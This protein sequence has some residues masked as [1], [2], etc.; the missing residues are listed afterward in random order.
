MEIENTVEKARNKDIVK[1]LTDQQLNKLIGSYMCL[2]CMNS[3]TGHCATGRPLGEE[4]IS[5]YQ[6]WLEEEADPT[7]WAALRSVL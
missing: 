5:G 7:N 1:T 4:C 2:A 3:I 6:E